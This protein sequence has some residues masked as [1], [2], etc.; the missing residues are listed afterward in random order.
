LQSEDDVKT[1]IRRLIETTFPIAP[2]STEAQREKKIRFGHPSTVMIW[3]ARRPVTTMRAA[4]FGSLLPAPT[5][6]AGRKELTDLVLRL[7]IWETSDQDVQGHILLQRARQ[8]LKEAVG[9]KPKV[10]DCFAGGGSIPLEALR[11]G[12]DAYA[13]EY[14]PVAVLILKATVDFPQRYGPRLA[15]KVREGAQWILTRARDS[16]AAYYPTAKDGEP[17]M[18][19]IWCRTIACPDCQGEVPLFGQL[20]LAKTKTKKVA[21]KIIPDKRH[22]R[23][24]FDIVRGAAVSTLAIDPDEGTT[25]GAT[26]RC[27]LCNRS[28]DANYVRR[29]AQQGRMGQRLVAV[30]T[31]QGRGEGREYRLPIRGDEEAVSK[32]TAACDKLAGQKF[33]ALPAIPQEVPPIKVHQVDQLFNYGLAS[34]GGIFSARQKLALVTFARLVREHHEEMVKTGVDKEFAEA[35][36]TCLAL[37]HTRMV[38]RCSTLVGWLPQRELVRNTMMGHKMNMVWDYTEINPISEGTG[39]WIN[40]VEYIYRF[41]EREAPTPG[42]AHVEHGSAAAL[43]YPDDYFDAVVSD[44]P[45]GANV[46]YADLA[47]FFYV[48]LKRTVGFLYPKLFRSELSERDQEITDCAARFG[49]DREKSRE[50]YESMMERALGEIA[51]V[52]KPDGLAVIVFAHKEEETWESLINALMRSGLAPVKTWPVQTEFEHSLHTSGKEAVISSV[53]IPCRKRVGKQVGYYDADMKRELETT[54]RDEMKSHGEAGLFGADFL[55]S[56]IGP[57]LRLFAQYSEIR[58]PDGTPMK[59]KEVLEDVRVLLG[60]LSTVA[61]A[62]SETQFYQFFRRLHG[63]EP[64][65]YDEALNIMKSFFAKEETLRDE[66]LLE[67]VKRKGA[68]QVRLLGALERDFDRL[69]GRVGAGFPLVNSVHYAALLWKQG[70]HRDLQA[71]LKVHGYDK[72]ADFWTLV[73][74]LAGSLPKDDEEREILAKMLPMGRGV[75]DRPKEPEL[76]AKGGKS[77]GKEKN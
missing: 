75:A 48:W 29:E 71:F 44:P 66:G 55:M 22:K 12:C 13:L 19:Y 5:S 39:S 16:L 56:A 8:M 33:D 9:R 18:A 27:L 68:V 45:Y 35:V 1:E 62:D 15:E 57:A 32:A 58:R 40:A 47:D 69:A 4:V 67:T 34:F 49:G 77:H 26:T 6:D 60:K 51:R 74:S 7:C 46:Y 42:V 64:G 53:I 31:T 63:H 17:V 30:V 20:W 37:G 73:Q 3:W 38:D 50:F 59:P 11:L 24:E 10:L 2:L 23:V 76:F 43:P 36:T 25:R 52:L 21:I 70:G 41:L 61:G 72:S 54:L 14:N 28:I 65:T